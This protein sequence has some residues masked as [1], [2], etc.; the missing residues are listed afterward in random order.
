MKKMKFISMVIL[1]ALLILSLTGCDDMEDE[2][3]ENDDIFTGLFTL[4][5]TDAPLDNARRVIVQ[6]TGIEI[7][8]ASGERLNFDFETPRQID[9]L[10]LNGGEREFLLSDQP[11]PAGHYDWIRLKVDAESDSDTMDSYIELEDGSTR[12]LKIPS[13]NQ[14][15]LK[16]ARGFEVPLGGITD[17]TI[18][19]DLRKSIHTPPDL[20]EDFILRPTLRMVDNTDAGKIAGTVDPIL[21][22]DPDNPTCMVYVFEN[23]GI[24]PDDIDGLDAEPITTAPVKFDAATGQYIYQA[25]F[26][27]AGDYTLALTYQAED[28][29][30]ETDDKIEFENSVQ[31]TVSPGTATTYEFQAR[32]SISFGTGYTGPQ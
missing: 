9:L 11:L 8:A 22:P 14:T 7:Q 31:V 2:A 17:F 10:A 28:D 26:L 13:I 15:G 16:L 20:D 18:D 27:N 24:T 3:M 1:N 32:K 23:L 29:D 6:F 4:G 21:I 25:A 5:I 19:F 30:P 12:S